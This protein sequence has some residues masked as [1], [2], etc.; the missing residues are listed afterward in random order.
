MIGEPDDLM[1]GLDDCDIAPLPP[2]SHALQRPS[3]GAA[4][5]PSAPEGPPHGE[6]VLHRRPSAAS[7]QLATARSGRGPPPQQPLL[8]SAAVVAAHQVRSAAMLPHLVSFASSVCVIHP[9]QYTA[10]VLL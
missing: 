1:F 8:S 3:S 10:V 4:A 6:G 7:L 2:A 9:M 5:R